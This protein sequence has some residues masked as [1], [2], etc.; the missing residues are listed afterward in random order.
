MHEIM[1]WVFWNREVMRSWNEKLCRS[2]Y[3]LSR[4]P[5]S[6]FEAHFPLM[7][8]NFCSVQSSLFVRRIF[9]LKFASEC[10]ALKSDQIYNPSKIRNTGITQQNAKHH[11]FLFKFSLH[12]AWNFVYFAFWTD[13]KMEFSSKG[14]LER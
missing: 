5:I 11:L 6:T 14:C 13:Y 8:R 9:E 4:V 3:L 1:R 2:V 7:V 10:A 12:C